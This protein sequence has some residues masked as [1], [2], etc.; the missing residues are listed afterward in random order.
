MRRK[1][2]RRQRVMPVLPNIFT[3][4]NLSFGLLSIM[5]SLQIMEGLAGGAS[6]EWLFRKFWWAGAFVVISFFFD[7]LDG[8]LARFI[9]HESNFGLSYD[10]LSDL[11][12]FGVA[13]GVL[14][15]VWTLLDAGKL[16]HMAL[17]FYIVCAAL[18]LARFNV[19]SGD[20][21]RFNFTGLP[22]PMAAGLM[23]S[24]LMLLS[25]LNIEPDARVMWFYLIAAPV[26]GLLMVSNVRYSK[27]PTVRLGGPFNALVV[28][29]IIIAAIITNPEIMFIFLVYLYALSGLAY[30]AYRQLKK[31]SEV[32]EEVHSGKSG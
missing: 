23:V 6:P 32:S 14:I 30:Y 25:S 17:L 12:S 26:I 13:P 24:P 3:T 29:A 11:V 16:G 28:A 4:G 19:Q 5:T 20:V 31:E 2:S 15:Y 9:K 10:S 18:R 7:T 8:K 22:S 21:E 1:K 27:R